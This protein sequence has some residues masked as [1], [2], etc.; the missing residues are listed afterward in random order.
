MDYLTEWPEE[1]FELLSLTTRQTKFDFAITSETITKYC[2]ER[3]HLISWVGKI[4]ETSCRKKFSFLIS[5][6]EKQKKKTSSLPTPPTPPLATN[7][8]NDTSNNENLS[9]DDMM[10]LISL[11]EVENMKRK[12][13][14]FNRV[15]S[16]LGC[17]PSSEMLT[18]SPEFSMIQQ[19]VEENKIKKDLELAR[20]EKAAKEQE[21]RISLENDR[22][23][24][25]RRFEI[26]SVDSEGINPLPENPLAYE[27][28][29][30][31]LGIFNINLN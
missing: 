10:D 21:E 31:L 16:S 11:Q 20:K 3:N 29:D 18:A 28:P 9:F 13:A 30:F 15:L 19:I 7:L 24:L 23:M 12:E 1:L 17:A 8:L 22:E 14:T 2:Q 5:N 4:T 27:V 6:A 26:N 25:R